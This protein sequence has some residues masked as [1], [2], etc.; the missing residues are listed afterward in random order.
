MP[1]RKGEPHVRW[2]RA[3]ESGVHLTAC[4]FCGRLSRK[5]VTALGPGSM[6]FAQR[7]TRMRLSC[8]F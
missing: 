8:V 1:K 4:A 6:I 5:A 7:E 3:E 2:G